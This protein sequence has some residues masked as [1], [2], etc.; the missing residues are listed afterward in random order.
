MQK[1]D[2]RIICINHSK[3]LGVYKSRVDAI[4]NAN[5]KYILLMDPDDIIFNQDIFQE[6]YNYYTKSNLDIIEF[7]VYHQKEGRKNIIFPKDHKFSQFNGFKKSIINQ[8]ELSEIIF[9]KP[10]TKEYSPVICR[11]I[12]NK[13]I[14]KEIIQ[15]S[16][17]YRIMIIFQI[18]F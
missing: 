1:S 5:G 4:L 2:K 10:N 14:R 11:T 13:L 16:I 12:W 8:P 7:L 17:H 9:Y 18:N 3:N 15:N 6:L